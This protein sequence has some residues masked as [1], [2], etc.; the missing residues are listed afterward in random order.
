MIVKPYITNSLT[1]ISKAL[2]GVVFLRVFVEYFGK[3]GVGQ[4]A[5]VQG[6]T[7]L[8][9]AMINGLFFSYVVSE[10]WKNEKNTEEIDI[11]HVFFLI[12]MISAIIGAIIFI[13]KNIIGVN[14]IE[15]KDISTEL[16]ILAIM[17]PIIGVYVGMSAK[18][19][20]DGFLTQFN[21]LNASGILASGLIVLL[22]TEYFRINGVFMAV[23]I[24]YLFPAL[25]IFY[26]YKKYI[27]KN[28]SIINIE[29][30]KKFPYESILSLSLIGLF[31]VVSAIV[32]KISVRNNIYKYSGWD[33]VGSWEAIN[34]IS[35][36][37]LLFVT[38]PLS[39]FLMPIISKNKN[40]ILNRNLIN[41]MIL[42]G[43]SLVFFA[44]M[45][46][47]LAWNTFFLKII[48]NQ[49]V[50]IKDYLLI[51]QVGD[52]FKIINWTLC[53]VALSYKKY[54]FIMIC[55]ITWAILYYLLLEFLLKTNGLSGTFYAYIVSNV[56]LTIIL[57]FE[58]LKFS[59]K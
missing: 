27:K 38:A 35:D 42:S 45:I 49:F 12:V 21:I 46:T 53:V 15:N 22:I 1:T 50:E 14:L 58:Y 17:C 10:A 59:K 7:T 48:G 24:Y 39:N 18:L 54:K 3:G 34:K 26:G 29:A 20:S 44:S 57:L 28:F 52:I 41:K 19:C 25:A 32:L 55:E 40:N 56:T 4:I 6:I 13:F 9:Y 11:N 36:T 33:D 8:V 23:S 47:H 31:T 43:I 30:I 37:Y 2:V 5:Q 16:T 51:Q